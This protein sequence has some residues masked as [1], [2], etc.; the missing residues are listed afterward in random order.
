MATKRT[1]PL[2]LERIKRCE[3]CGGVL[4]GDGTSCTECLNTFLASKQGQVL[5]TRRVGGHYRL[6]TKTQKPT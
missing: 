1:F 4:S 6:V 2:V 5:Y 3:F